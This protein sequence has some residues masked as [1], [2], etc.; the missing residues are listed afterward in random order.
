MDLD[1]YVQ[2]HAADWARLEAL[3]RQS[4]LSGAEVDELMRRYEQVATHL[5]V[6]RTMAPDASLVGHVSMI[7]FRARV[8]AE[9]TR[10]SSWTGV[11]R[12]F[13]RRFPAALY[14]LRGWWL[15]VLVA[16]VVVAA[17]MIWW[18][19]EHPAF[20]QSLLGQSQ[21]DDLVGT[22]I[23]QYY[24]ESAHQD[25]ALQV[26][27][28]NAWVA[29]LCMALGVLG[30]PVV[31][32][33]YSNISNL[34]VLATLMHRAERGELFWGLILPHGLLELTAVFVAAGAGLRFFWS[35]VSPGDLTRGQSMAREGR[36]I[37]TLALGLTV[38]LLVTG[39]IEGFVTPS[40]WPTWIRVGIGVVAEL[41]FLA[42]V[43]VVGRRAVALGEDGDI[44]S[45][46]GA[47]T[48]TRA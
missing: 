47:R 18:M 25:F 5:S 7:L 33:L 41:L 46:A 6:I 4:T 13:T 23:E 31:L 34:A 30:L 1:A 8:R 14:R 42:Y 28:N 20:E 48:L 24:Y 15:G 10:T 17:V 21:I 43:F 36:T 39:L 32:L 19:V 9:S 29:A 12:F 11:G 35:W 38:V 27:T 2:T 45:R 16:N 44:G 37:A 22:D 3:T 40:G 26:W